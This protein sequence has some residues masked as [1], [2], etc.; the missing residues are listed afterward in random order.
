M[1]SEF[2]TQKDG[3]NCRPI[4]A[5]FKF[6]ELFGF[7]PVAKIIKKLLFPHVLYRTL[8]FEQQQKMIEYLRDELVASRKIHKDRILDKNSIVCVC[9]YKVHASDDPHLVFML[10]CM[11]IRND[12]SV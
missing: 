4:I 7:T 8:V 1:T 2:I 12:L 9:N 6:M 11:N 3:H 10:I 5:R